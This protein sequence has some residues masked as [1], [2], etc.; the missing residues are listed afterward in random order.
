M[1]SYKAFVVNRFIV[2][3]LLSVGLISAKEGSAQ[4][5]IQLFNQKN[6]EGWYAWEPESGKHT[7]ASE[8]FTVENNLI[9]LFGEKAGYLMSEQSFHDFQLTVE[10]RWNIDTTYIR[11]S[12]TKNSGVM[13]LVP[14]DTPDILWPAGIQ[15]QIKEGSTGDFILLQNVTL[16]VKGNVTEPGKSVVIKGVEDTSNAEG[17]WNRLVITVSNGYIMQELN[18]KLVNEGDNPSVS[19]GRILLQ[20]E[21]YPI[22]FRKVEI[23]DLSKGMIMD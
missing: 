15:F 4:S 9:R 8:L 16:H 13:Y 23:R 1:N 22:D 14:M 2:L 17:E 10:Y 11:K 6:L 21:G 5:V 18:G 20:Y 12:N 7:D 3:I 19:E